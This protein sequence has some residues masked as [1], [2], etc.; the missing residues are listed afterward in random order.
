MATLGRDS[1]SRSQFAACN[2]RNPQ[3]GTRRRVTSTDDEETLCDFLERY[4]PRPYRRRGAADY[5]AAELERV[6][7]A[8]GLFCLNEVPKQAPLGT[9]RQS[10]QSDGVN[11]HLW[12]I[13]ER[14]RPCISQA[15]LPRLGPK[16]LHHTNLTGGGK[17][18]IGGE[19]WFGTLPFAYLSG[20]SG[21]YPP[22]GPGHLEDA[23][24]LFR[25]VGF[26]VHSLGWDPETDS[27]RRVWLERRSAVEG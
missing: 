6:T 17:A 7:T 1:D 25:A 9:P 21:R 13:D 11:C 3:I 16:E 5:P 14:G 2:G 12:V 19:I 8:D 23:E 4:P 18:S 15:P 24:R 27:P 20:S 10:S 26:D 22:T